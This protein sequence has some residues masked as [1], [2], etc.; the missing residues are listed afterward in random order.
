MNRLPLRKEKLIEQCQFKDSEFQAQVKSLGPIVEQAVKQNNTINIYEE[1][2]SGRLPDHSSEAPYAKG[3][4]KFRDPAPEGLKRSACQVCW[5]P[6]GPTKLAVAYSVL[7]FQVKRFFFH[8]YLF[9]F[10]VWGGGDSPLLFVFD[11]FLP[12]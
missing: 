1:Y 8:L 3:L 11:W 12:F 7:N 2:F 6:E 5:H 4:A 9:L 10:I